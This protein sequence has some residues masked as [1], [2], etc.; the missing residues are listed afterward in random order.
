MLVK[1]GTSVEL[2]CI[3]EIEF[4]NIEEC[5]TSTASVKTELFYRIRVL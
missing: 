2:E 4:L 5:K 3:R 1:T